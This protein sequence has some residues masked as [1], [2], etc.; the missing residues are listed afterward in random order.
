MTGDCH[1]RFCESRRVRPPPATHQ[2]PQRQ[3]LADQAPPGPAALHPDQRQLAEHGGNLLRDHH[4]PSDPPRHLPLRPAPRRA[5]VAGART[6]RSTATCTCRHEECS[7]PGCFTACAVSVRSAAPAAARCPPTAA[8]ASGTWSPSTP[9]RS[10]PTPA[11]SPG[12]G[13]LNGVVK[14][15]EPSPV[16]RES[17]CGCR[18]A[19]P[20]GR[21]CVGGPA[22]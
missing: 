21:R 14:Q 19:A 9:A 18:A 10:K 22:R 16:G 6:R 13:N 7:T 12:T 4:P 20:I 5:R 15:L 2:A 17:R 1:V 3:D 11:R 8:G